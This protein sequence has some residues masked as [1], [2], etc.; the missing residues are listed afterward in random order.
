MIR[1]AC[2]GCGFCTLL[3]LHFAGESFHPGQWVRQ[4]LQHF[5]LFVAGLVTAGAVMM[6]RLL[7]FRIVVDTETD[8]RRLLACADGG[9][10][11][12][13]HRCAETAAAWRR[14]GK[15]GWRN[16]DG[17][18]PIRREND[19]SIA[20]VLFRVQNGRQIQIANVDARI[21]TTRFR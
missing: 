7:I 17:R 12:H 15:I 4:P 8:T 16:C 20:V 1:I 10:A 9:V 11:A 19:V 6:M 5:I 13:A 2:I 18:H 14:I 21:V 3:W